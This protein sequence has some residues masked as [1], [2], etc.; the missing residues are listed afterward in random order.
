[1]LLAK[2]IF[3][4][5]GETLKHQHT[6]SNITLFELLLFLYVNLYIKKTTHHDSLFFS[7]MLDHKQLRGASHHLL[8][9]TVL[10][11]LFQLLELHTSLLHAPYIF[12]LHISHIYYIIII[13]SNLL[14]QLWPTLSR[15]IS[16]SFLLLLSPVLLLLWLFGFWINFF[17]VFVPPSLTYFCVFLWMLIYPPFYRKEFELLFPTPK[18]FKQVCLKFYFSSPSCAGT[19]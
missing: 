9:M 17:L 18:P 8:H 2:V 6:C 15:I 14:R 16:T 19:Q 3:N 7:L 5:H 12:F 10:Q 13:Y 4:K 1:M 11:S